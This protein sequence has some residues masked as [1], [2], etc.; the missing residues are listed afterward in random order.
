MAPIKFE[1]DLKDRL[2]KRT[3]NPS[4]KTWDAL[5]NRLDV[6]EQKESKTGFQWFAIAA[7]IV[8][9]L[10]VVYPILKK[11]ITTTQ[12]PT[13]VDIN[14]NKTMNTEDTVILSPEMLEENTTPIVVKNVIESNAKRPHGEVKNKPQDP[15]G[16]V[17]NKQNQQLLA[18]NHISEI[19]VHESLL[20]DSQS[21]KM[22]ADILV[23]TRKQDRVIMG[24]EN[25]IDSLLS[26]AREDIVWRALNKNTNVPIDHNEI[27][28]DVEDDLEESLR[29][30]LLKTVRNG[31][32]SIRAELA[33]RND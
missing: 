10:C 5:S 26:R 7:S 17:V 16:T 12:P 2:E 14:K 4:D 29:D 31:Y 23:S 1:E 6:E 25:N 30:K 33:E 32:S 22:E 19:A 21:N 18:S 13:V 9:L 8:G 20:I 11:D 27:L 28:Q 15:Q 3:I 24:S